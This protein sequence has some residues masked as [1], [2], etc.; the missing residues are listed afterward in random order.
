M[1]AI[2]IGLHNI[3]EGMAIAVPLING[4]MKRR[5]AVLVTALSGV[6]TVIGGVLGYW[7]GEIGP[8]GLALSLSFASG[9]MLYVVFAEILPQSILMYRSKLPAFFAIFGVLVGLAVIFA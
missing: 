1:L 2:L 7:L 5:L 8:L 3:P 9:A 6:P 4:G